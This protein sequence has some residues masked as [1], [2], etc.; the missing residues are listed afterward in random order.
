TLE[1]FLG[2]VGYQHNCYL[3]LLGVKSLPGMAPTVKS[4]VPNS[5]STAEGQNVGITGMNFDPDPH[6]TS[7]DFGTIPAQ[8]TY[9]S[10]TQ[11]T[12]VA[13][14]VVGTVD[15]IVTTQYGTSGVTPLDQ[16]TA[17]VPAAFAPYVAAVDP[18]SGP[19]SGGTPITITGGSFA[20]GCA[21]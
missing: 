2:Q 14:A 17:P 1:D 7:V 4:V 18:N 11:I 19:K 20:P 8:Y 10:P 21:V 3:E 12:A 15:V 9:N 6:Y 16:Y 13:P 5:G